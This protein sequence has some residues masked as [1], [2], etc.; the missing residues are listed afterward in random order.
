MAKGAIHAGRLPSEIH[1][2]ARGANVALGKQEIVGKSSKLAI[3]AP[4]L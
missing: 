4:S 1:M 2:F 3:D